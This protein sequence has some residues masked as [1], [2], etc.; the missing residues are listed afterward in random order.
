MTRS[1]QFFFYMAVHVI[2]VHNFHTLSNG[3]VYKSNGSPQLAYI[4]VG[5]GLQHL[6]DSSHVTSTAIVR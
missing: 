2:I 3:D 5:L 1:A 4:C 6:L